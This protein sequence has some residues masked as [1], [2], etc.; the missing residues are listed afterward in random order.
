MRS[1]HAMRSSRRLDA[2]SKIADPDAQSDRIPVARAM[3]DCGVYVDGERLPEKY[4]HAEAITKVHELERDGQA[5]FVYGIELGIVVIAVNEM[6]FED[7]VVTC[8][9]APHGFDHGAAVGADLR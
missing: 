7:P 6:A 2:R 3:V 1:F 4:G 5:A 8:F 9:Q